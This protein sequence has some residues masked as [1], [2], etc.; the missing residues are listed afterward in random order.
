MS[1][2]CRQYICIVVIIACYNRTL[3]KND[4]TSN[5]WD[6]HNMEHV[7]RAWSGYMLQRQSSTCDM[8]VFMK[9]LCC[10]DN[11]VSAACCMR[12]ILFESVCHEAETVTMALF[13]MT[14]VRSAYLFLM[15]QREYC[16]V[17]CICMDRE[18]II[19]HSSLV[20][21]IFIPKQWRNCSKHGYKKNWLI[22]KLMRALWLVNQLWFKLLCQ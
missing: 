19:L 13:L 20:F 16:S 2:H 9:T 7:A 10:G 8:T 21:G 17:N 18:I 1:S 6:R 3:D 14:H 5:V 11:F 12:F 22:T 15:S 4:F